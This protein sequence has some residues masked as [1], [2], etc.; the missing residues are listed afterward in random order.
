MKLSFG[1]YQGVEIAKVPIDYLWWLI[2][3]NVLQDSRAQREVERVLGIDSSD[4]EELLKE[5]NRRLKDEIGVLRLKLQTCIQQSITRDKLYRA[6]Q[7]LAVKLH[8]DRGGNED[9]M[10]GVNAMMDDLRA[11]IEI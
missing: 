8:P 4:P 7:S 5:E 3:N 11:M 2:R 9:I 10:R 1:K 6:F